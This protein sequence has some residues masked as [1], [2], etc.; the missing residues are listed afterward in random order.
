MTQD[1][2]TETAIA[3]TDRLKTA[4]RDLRKTFD[5]S[6]KRCSIVDEVVAQVAAST[7]KDVDGEE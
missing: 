6:G 3:E 4:L 5:K 2:R 7:S 1:E